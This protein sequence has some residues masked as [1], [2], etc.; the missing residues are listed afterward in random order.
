MHFD[1]GAWMKLGL[2]LGHSPSR[3]RVPE[4]VVFG[5]GLM[6]H[7][8]E[9][10]VPALREKASLVERAWGQRFRFSKAELANDAGM[11]GAAFRA[12]KGDE[13]R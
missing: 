7:Q 1:V 12:L 9:V 5:G 6:E 10:F 2:F 13:V 3:P 8:F 4:K 11:V